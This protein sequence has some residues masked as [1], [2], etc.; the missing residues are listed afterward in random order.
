MTCLQVCA[1]LP[2][3]TKEGSTKTQP[4]VVQSKPQVPNVDHENEKMPSIPSETSGFEVHEL[5]PSP[6]PASPPPHRGQMKRAAETGAAEETSKKPKRAIDK[7]QID[8]VPP[9]TAPE[10]AASASTRP[11]PERFDISTPRATDSD[12]CAASQATSRSRS[13][14]DAPGEVDPLAGGMAVDQTVSAISE[15]LLQ[16]CHTRGAVRGTF[17]TREP[18]ALKTFRKHGP[19]LTW[20][21]T[22]GSSS[23]TNY[24]FG[25]G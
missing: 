22:V 8:N 25:L 13:P 15:T 17:G 5:M 6:V 18:L 14:R 11:Q 23:R 16:L 12:H 24:V 21:R 3:D 7:L 1:G 20:V 19:N 9:E 2:W 4:A 10:Q